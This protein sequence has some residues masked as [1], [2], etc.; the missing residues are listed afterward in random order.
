LYAVEIEYR[1]DSELKI[2]YPFYKFSAKLTNSAG[3][4]IEA[5]IITPAVASAAQK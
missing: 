4:N 3:I 1:Y 5:K 2:A